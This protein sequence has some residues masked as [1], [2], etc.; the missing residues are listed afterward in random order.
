M[1]RSPCAPHSPALTL[2]ALMVGRP[3][4]EINLAAVMR[5]TRTRFRD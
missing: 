1:G 2:R 4:T 5:V 3:W